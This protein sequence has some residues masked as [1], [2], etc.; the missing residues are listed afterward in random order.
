MIPVA[1]HA[2]VLYGDLTGN[3]TDQTGAVVPNADVTAT[4]TGTG[5][6]STTKTDDRGIFEFT[7]LVAGTYKLTITA[8][9]LGTSV[10][11]GLAIKT[12]N[13]LRADTVLT[14]AGKTETVTVAATAPVLQTDRGDIHTDLNTSEIGNLPINSSQGRNFQSLY[15]VIPGFS[16]PAEPNS[17]SGNPQRGMTAFVNGVSAQ[18]NTTRVDGQTDMY[19]WLPAN[20]AYLPPADSVETVN[21]VTN[22]F[23]A[24]QGMAGGAAVNITIKSGTNKFHGGAFFGHN[25]QHMTALNFFT[26]PN[27][28]GPN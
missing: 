16:T 27:E 14:V 25:D 21:I 10:Q 5:L 3:V 20:V 1:A 15:K 2:Q 7:D 17:V 26:Q 13:V 8:P 28:Y 23:D 12:N 4:D 11:E 18:T 24:E 19:P 6:V 9:G 22:S